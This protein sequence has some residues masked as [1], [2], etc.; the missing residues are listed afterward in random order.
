MKSLNCNDY[1]VLYDNVTSRVKVNFKKGVLEQLSQNDDLNGGFDDVYDPADDDPCGAPAPPA[2]K[3]DVNSVSYLSK[4]FTLNLSG[5]ESNVDTVQVYCKPGGS[6]PWNGGKFL[7]TTDIGWTKVSTNVA[8]I[9]SSLLIPLIINGADLNSGTMWAFA[10]SITKDGAGLGK[11]AQYTFQG[12]NI[13]V[14]SVLFSSPK[15]TLNLSDQESK[16]KS[17]QVYCK[18]S[19]TGTWLGGKFLLTADIGWTKVSTDVATVDSAKLTTLIPSSDLSSGTAWAFSV[20]M[21]TGPPLGGQGQ[22]IIT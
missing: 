1:C 18:P 13:D 15:F 14:N 9:D 2:V 20:S 16:V 10:V 3:I 12:G 22:I 6:G 21:T 11:Q 5:D 7:S 8:T 17:V 19:G 4:K